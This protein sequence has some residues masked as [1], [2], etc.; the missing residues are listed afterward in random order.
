MVSFTPCYHLKYDQDSTF[1]SLV[2]VTCCQS[3]T[4]ATAMLS[5]FKLCGIVCPKYLLLVNGNARE[6]GEHTGL[7]QQINTSI[8]KGTAVA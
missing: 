1:I 8:T 7:S 4:A 6:A 5:H 3:M 2:S